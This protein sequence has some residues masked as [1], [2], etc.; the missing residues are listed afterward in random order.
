MHR[1]KHTLNQTL[2]RELHLQKEWAILNILCAITFHVLY[3]IVKLLHQ[4]VAQ[5]V[6]LIR[7]FP[8]PS[9]LVVYATKRLVQA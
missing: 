2:Y 5:A 8:P 6:S 3:Q 7:L 9:Q 4:T 1:Q